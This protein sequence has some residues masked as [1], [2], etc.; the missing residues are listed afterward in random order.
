[1]AQS[2]FICTTAPPCGEEEKQDWNSQ[3]SLRGVRSGIGPPDIF[4]NGGE[5]TS[6][7]KPEN[8]AEFLAETCPLKEQKAGTLE[9]G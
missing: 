4:T 6:Q 1:M 8:Q 7:V 5:D 2:L 3:F 9:D